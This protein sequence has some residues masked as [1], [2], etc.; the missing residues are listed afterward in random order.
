MKKLS[1]DLTEA[2]NFLLEDESEVE[3]LSE[4]MV[5]ILGKIF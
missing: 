5:V 1:Y 4:K 2:I 3:E